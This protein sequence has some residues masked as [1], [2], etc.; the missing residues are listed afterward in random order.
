MALIRAHDL[1][2]VGP[3]GGTDGEN[4]TVHRV[5]LRNVPAFVAERRALGDAIDGKLL[6]V[7]GPHLV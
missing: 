4:I 6:L 7:M 5:A 2:K 3:G 1:T